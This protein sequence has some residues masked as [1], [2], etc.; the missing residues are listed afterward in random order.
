[1]L[2]V[3]AR[4]IFIDMMWYARGRFSLLVGE[5]P[6]RPKGTDCKSVDSVFAG[7]NPA[8]TTIDFLFSYEENFSRW[9]RLCCYVCFL[10]GGNSS[11]G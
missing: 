3:Q 6:E 1:M 9:V 10:V 5:V 7:S 4:V 11:I 2:R 8:L